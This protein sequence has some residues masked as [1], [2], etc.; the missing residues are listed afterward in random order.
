MLKNLRNTPFWKPISWVYRK[1][2]LKAKVYSR[3]LFKPVTTISLF[4]LVGKLNPTKQIIRKE[5]F[6]ENSGVKPKTG[7]MPEEDML[8]MTKLFSYIDPKTCFEFGTNW[9]YTTAIFVLNTA[10]DAKIWTLDICREMF[11][12]AQLK[13]DSELDEM[14]MNKTQTGTVYKQ[15][16]ESKQK[17]VQIYEDSM[18]FEW[19]NAQPETYDF[20][21]VDAC[22]AYDFVK[23]DTEKSLRRLKKGG[24]LLWHDYYPDVSAWTDVFTYVN[25]F[26]K[27]YPG[28]MHIKGTHIAVYIKDHD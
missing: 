5:A 8:A 11:S 4:E 7:P 9:G 21:F 12:E 25:E 3:S 28:V 15:L 2:G 24:L 19:S 13:S 1:T 20:M 10:S 23:N 14:V 27:Q 16:E 6:F 17:V 22:H 26:A 18:K